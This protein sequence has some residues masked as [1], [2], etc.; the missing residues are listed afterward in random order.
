MSDRVIVVMAEAD[1]RADLS[2][3]EEH[4]LTEREARLRDALRAALDT[5]REELVERIKDGILRTFDPDDVAGTVE[6]EALVHARA[7]L[8][9]IEE[10]GQQC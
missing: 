8:A 9:A 4:R 2:Y 7:A 6:S 10:G 3:L 5:D 1:A